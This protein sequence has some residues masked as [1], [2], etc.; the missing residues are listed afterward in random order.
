MEE[1]VHIGSDLRNGEMATTVWTNI[2][3]CQRS[4]Q[5][6]LEVIK[7]RVLGQQACVIQVSAVIHTFER[8]ALP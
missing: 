8:E 7:V 5:V 3:S 2:T 4:F 1:Q 6:G